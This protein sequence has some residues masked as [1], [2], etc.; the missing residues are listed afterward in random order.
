M[1]NIALILSILISFLGCK[2]QEFDEF[3]FSFGNSFETDFS[4]KF[5]ST[6][7][8]IFLYENWAPVNTKTPKGKTS[9]VALFNKNQ[10]SKLDS[11]I[12]NIDFKSLDTLYFENYQDGEYYNFFIR[13]G[14]LKKTIKIHSNNAPKSLSNFAHWIYETKKILKL[15]ETQRSFEFKSKNTYLEPPLP[16]DFKK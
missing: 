1:K 10:R 16:S 13:K 15:T 11:F 9:Y 5:N 3:D 6:N 12:A 2:K 8:S 4:I 7:D 14:K